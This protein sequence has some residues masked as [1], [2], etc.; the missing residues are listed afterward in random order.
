MRAR[1]K[2]RLHEQGAPGRL[3]VH[4][5]GVPNRQVSPVTL[6]LGSLLRSKA[7]TG[8]IEGRWLYVGVRRPE[9]R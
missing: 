1:E 5:P 8:S 6:G 2:H 7:T 4:S 3:R 9:S